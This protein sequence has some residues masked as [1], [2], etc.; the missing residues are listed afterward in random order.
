VPK[1]Y[2]SSSV[3]LA[4]EEKELA[5]LSDAA[6]V[7]NDLKGPLQVLHEKW[8]T[9]YVG[10]IDE[11]CEKG[12]AWLQEAVKRAMATAQETDE[13]SDDEEEDETP[14]GSPATPI[15]VRQQIRLSRRS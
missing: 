3:Q 6:N 13:R 10:S 11:A 2:D 1:S 15:P 12:E 9:D 7:L 5:D 8:D 14:L 4:G